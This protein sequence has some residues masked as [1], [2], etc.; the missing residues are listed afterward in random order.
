MYRYIFLFLLAL[1]SCHNKPSSE[2]H[3]IT[4]DIKTDSIYATNPNDSIFDKQVIVKNNFNLFEDSNNI[5][6]VQ[7]YFQGPDS[8]IS[9]WGGFV[10]KSEFNKARY[11]WTSDSS[12]NMTL[13]NTENDSSKAVFLIGSMD[14]KTGSNGYLN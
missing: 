5:Y 2:L 12:I 13:F 6:M 14:G 10:E 3:E 7:L 11:H 8:L 1:S 4:I 9:F